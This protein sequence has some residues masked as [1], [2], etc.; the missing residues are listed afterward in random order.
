MDLTPAHRGEHAVRTLVRRVLLALLTIVAGGFLSATLVRYAPGFGSDE[1][2]LDSRLSHESL[3]II[4]HE[5]S[6]QGN[7]V[8]YYAGY[9]RR[10]AHGDLGYSR[11]LNR[12]VRELLAERAR[13]TARMV[14]EGMGIAWMAALLLAVAVWW[15]STPALEVLLT[16]FSGGLL[17]LPAAGVALLSVVLNQA[18]YLAIAIVVFP[19]VFR[20]LSSLIATTHAMPHIVTAEAKGISRSRVFFCHVLPVVD[21]EVLAL[22]G[23]S[24]GLAISAAIP[25]EALCG[26]PGVGQLAWQSAMGRDLPL[27]T[28]IAILVVAC[29]TLANSGADLLGEGRRS[30]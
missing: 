27:L 17:C 5:T 18:G 30:I 6:A 29:V 12:P 13:V 16:V 15:F 20:Y 10:M 3:V 1:R 24:L 14:G 11:L 7:V 28:Q 22:A 21:R 26:I 4:R 9:L 2:Q 25:V 8:A 19:K 23:V